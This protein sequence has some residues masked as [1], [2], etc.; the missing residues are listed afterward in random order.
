MLGSYQK[1]ARRLRMENRVRNGRIGKRRA[2]LKKRSKIKEVVAT[3]VFNMQLLRK[4][5]RYG[6]FSVLIH[7]LQIIIR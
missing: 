6:G 1:R 2:M 3:F 4:I 7:I 5:I